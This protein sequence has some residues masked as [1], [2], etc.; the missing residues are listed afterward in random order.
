MNNRIEFSKNKLAQP[1]AISTHEV[2]IAANQLDYVPDFLI[3]SPTKTGTNW[4]FRN[5]DFHPQAFIPPVKELEYFSLA[6]KWFNM[7]WYLSFFKP[8]VGKIKGESS[9]LYASLPRHS[10]QAIYSMNPNIKLIF[11]MRDPIGR[12]WS[13][14]KHD[15]KFRCLN[16]CSFKGEFAQVT[17]A[18]WMET[19][20]QTTHLVQGDYLG[21]L[22]RWLSVFPANQ[23]YI[24]FFESIVHKPER[25]LY[26][27][28]QFLGLDFRDGINQGLAKAKIF[29]GIEEDLP[30]ELSAYLRGLF[31]ERTWELVANLRRSS[32]VTPPPEWINTLKKDNN[33]DVAPWW[34]TINDDRLDAMLNEIGNNAIFPA[35]IRNPK[36]GI[37]LFRSKYY[38]VSEQLG[39][40]NFR[41]LDDNILQE[42]IRNGLCFVGD[43]ID[44]V[45]YSIAQRL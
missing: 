43:S 41:L 10:I 14:A 28:Y 3:I 34:K 22:Q 37:Y 16:F 25:L 31:R 44:E 21:C 35:D 6:W 4:L 20:N 11:L 32:D 36:Y 17:N 30:D 33:P 19:F 23:I 26:E 13:H 5:I 15:F 1:G 24:E 27:I 8:G 45:R 38:A 18:K 9:P 29:A 39:W 2:E 40:I 42:H 12:A 7:D